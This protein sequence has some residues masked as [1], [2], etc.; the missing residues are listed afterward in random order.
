MLAALA[1]CIADGS[2]ARP[3]GV[4]LSQARAPRPPGETGSG[5]AEVGGHEGLLDISAAAP[6]ADP[7]RLLQTC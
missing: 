5:W 4:R 3:T 2:A 1:L 6:T 7:R